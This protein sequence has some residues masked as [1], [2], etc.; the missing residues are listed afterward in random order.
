MNITNLKYSKED[1]S[2]LCITELKNS[3]EH[4][5]F[6]PY[7]S[8]TWVAAHIEEWLAVEGNEIAPFLTLAEQLL[9]DKS[10]RGQAINEAMN[11]RLLDLIPNA[12]RLKDLAQE[13]KDAGD[14]V[15]Q[16]NAAAEAVGL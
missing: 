9:L 5:F 16:F 10:V 14:T 12:D 6:S 3:K 11:A 7:P 13:A 1:G 2:Q 8:H 4:S 15:D